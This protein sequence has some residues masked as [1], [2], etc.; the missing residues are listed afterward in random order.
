[1]IYGIGKEPVATLP[2]KKTRR[3]PGAPV[4]LNMR[5]G[6]GSLGVIDLRI[7]GEYVASLAVEEGEP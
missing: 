3:D 5:K 2:T 1:M 7:L 6:G 4:E